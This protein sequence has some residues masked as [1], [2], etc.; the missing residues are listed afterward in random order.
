MSSKGR[1]RRADDNQTRRTVESR[2]RGALG[3]LWRSLWKHAPTPV[4]A[5][6][7][8]GRYRAEARARFWTEFREGQ[9]EAEAR[10]SR[11]R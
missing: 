11:P 3:C 10:S 7:E 4:K 2:L 9:R 5:D 1:A 6:H 8:E